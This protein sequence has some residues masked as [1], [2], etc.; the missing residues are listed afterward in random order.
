MTNIATM[1]KGEILRLARK[2][3]RQEVEGLKKASAAYRSEIAALKRRLDVL[4]K[5]S[6]R[7]Q[8]KAVVSPEPEESIK[9]RFSAKG[10]TKHRERLGLS[11]SDY[12][13][14]LGVSG[15]TVYNWEAEKSRPRQ[16]QLQ[17]IA[18]VR[19]IGK[20]QA[21]VALANTVESAE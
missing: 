16:A 19:K 15:Q 2:E 7:A 20:R 8:R 5:S 13:K 17:A 10:L 6:R 1:L 9:V 12:G 3:V 21:K 4:E 18:A 14:L 11:A